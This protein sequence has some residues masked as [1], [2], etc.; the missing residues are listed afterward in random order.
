MKTWDQRHES[1][2]C[3]EEELD[4]AYPEDIPVNPWDRLDH[5]LN[6]APTLDEVWEL[7]ALESEDEREDRYGHQHDDID[8]CWN[9][10]HYWHDDYDDNYYYYE[11]YY[12]DDAWEDSYRDD[13][14]LQEYEEDEA[15][16][17][18]YEDAS[19]W[20]TT[21]NEIAEFNESCEPPQPEPRPL[22]SDHHS[23]K[24]A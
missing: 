1:Q 2:P 5:I 21:C 4:P 15:N 8:E 11:D 17:K 3:W 22:I 12:E 20:R 23:R 9:N 14:G 7:C 24:A 6:P 19:V 16:E 18:R 10:H 13:D